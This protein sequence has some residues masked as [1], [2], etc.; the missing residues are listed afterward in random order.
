MLPNEMSPEDLLGKQNQLFRELMSISGFDPFAQHSTSPRKQMFANHLGQHLVIFGA[1]PRRIQTGME[2]RY[3]ETTFRVEAPDDIEI[4]KVIERYPRGHGVDSISINPQTIIIYEVRATKL[5]GIIELKPYTSNHPYFGY[6][7]VSKPVLGRIM[8]GMGIPKG[9]VLQDSPAVTENGDYMYG[10]EANIAPMTMPGTSEDGT[11][12]SES[13]ARKMGYVTFESRTVEFGPDLIPLN[14]YG[15]EHRYQICPEVGQKVKENGILFAARR[16][17]ED[18]S[19]FDQAP[20]A[21]RQFYPKFDKPIY[22]PPGGTV[23]DIQ[24]QHDP[25]SKQARTP[26]GM[27]QQMRK[28]QEATLRFYREIYS[29]YIKLKKLRQ[30]GLSLTPEFHMLLRTAEAVL[31]DSETNRVTKVYKRAKLD[32][33]RVTFVIRT[34]NI[35]NIGSKITGCHGDKGI[36]VQV[37]KDEHMPVDDFGN[38]ADIVVDPLATV[39]RSILGRVYEPKYNAVHRDLVKRIKAEL[40]LPNIVTPEFLRQRNMNGEVFLAFERVLRFY[41]IMSPDFTYRCF[42]ENMT[43]DDKIKHMA[44]ILTE[45]IYLFMPPENEPESPHIVVQLNKEFPHD[46]SQVTYVGNSGRT[47]RTREVIPIATA[48]VMVLDKTGGEWAAVNAGR[49]QHHGILAKI[50]PYDRYSS[51]ARENPTRA[52]GESEFRNYLSYLKEFIAAELMDRNNNKYV[53][54]HMVD[55]LLSAPNPSNIDQLVD[56]SVIPYGEAKPLQIIRHQGECGGWRLTWRP[57]VPLWA[58]QQDVGISHAHPHP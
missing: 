38:R 6:D 17:N 42:A 45:G 41:Q 25:Y 54:E 52:H 5:A 36:V 7:N 19:I 28:Y 44:I 33:W 8:Q 4:V 32:D 37:V 20:H 30:D 46:A 3:A 14:T 47:V 48:Y 31:D 29:T 11:I 55:G 13:F 49:F 50:S 35:P 40:N 56:R 22:A 21:L 1:T 24:V 43:D 26:L 15:D 18:T 23:I 39:G 58:T 10:I 12:I 27:D 51:P 16:H 53:I 2:R 34:E 9:T 57:H